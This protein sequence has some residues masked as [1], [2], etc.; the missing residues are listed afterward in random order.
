MGTLLY[1]PSPNG[2]FVI[3]DRLMTVDEIL[4]K[5]V[6]LCREH[7]A[8]SITLFGSRAKGTARHDS[9]IDI[10]VSGV[11]DIEVL[12]E[13]IAEIPTLYS[14]DIVDLDACSDTRRQEVLKSGRT[15]FS[16]YNSFKKSLSLLM[17]AKSRDL[18]DDLM[19][20]GVGFIFKRT[21]DLAWKSLRDFLHTHYP[22]LTFMALSPREVLKTAS[23]AGLIADNEWMRMLKL[24]TDL[25]EDYEEIVLKNNLHRITHDYTNVLEALTR[26]F[27]ARAAT[28]GSGCIS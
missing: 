24:R 2:K 21:F 19:V 3:R 5:I 28:P 17:E 10:A 14:V 13:E 15:L 26:T 16:F 8:T 12:K 1:V 9:D 11:N 27:E 25:N 20:S 7:D 22:C 18:T 6:V 4:P 23:Q